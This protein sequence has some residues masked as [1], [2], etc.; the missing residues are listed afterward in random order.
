MVARKP[1]KSELLWVGITVVEVDTD[2]VDYATHPAAAQAV[3][4]EIISSLATTAQIL[5]EGAGAAE[6]QV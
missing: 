5:R 6:S 4:G 3:A 1:L 2:E